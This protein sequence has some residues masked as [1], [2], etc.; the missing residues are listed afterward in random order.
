MNTTIGLIILIILSC[1]VAW[2]GIKAKL[3]EKK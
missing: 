2:W 1:V 3:N